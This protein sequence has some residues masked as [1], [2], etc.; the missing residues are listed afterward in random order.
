M[1]VIG[2]VMGMVGTP[3][4]H[5][6]GVIPVLGAKP[7]LPGADAASGIGPGVNSHDD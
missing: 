2:M 1:M 3:G 5:N 4:F 6:G 7:H